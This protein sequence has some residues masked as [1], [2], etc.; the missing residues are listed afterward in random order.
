MT[1]EDLDYIYILVDVEDSPH[2]M[3]K[4]IRQLTD[5]EFRNWIVEFAAYNGVTIIPSFGR[6]GME[7]RLSMINYL[8]RSGVFIA[9]QARPEDIRRQ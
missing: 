6:M 9:R 4:S 2:R 5:A 8:I 3:P 1:D 7:T